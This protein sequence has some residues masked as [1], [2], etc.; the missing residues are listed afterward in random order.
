MRTKNF[1]V[2]DFVNGFEKNAT[3]NLKQRYIKDNLQIK[4][5]INI[6]D[7]LKIAEKITSATMFVK[8]KTNEKKNRLKVN[9]VSRFILFKL[10]IVDEYSNIN[11]DF[12]NS[13]DEYDMLVKSGVADIVAESVPMSEKAEINTIV[14]MMIEDIMTNEYE[15]S[16]YIENQIERITYTA[17]EVFAPLVEVLSKQLSDT[18]K[19][20]SE[21]VTKEDVK[22]ILELIRKDKSR[23]LNMLIK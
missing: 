19:E 20:L 3:D 6:E 11:V 10:I 7:K 14:Q 15:T 5:Y 4:P 16:K 18:I 23:F 9:S 22:G 17:K 21:D 1:T 13:T 8:D 2:K 12:S